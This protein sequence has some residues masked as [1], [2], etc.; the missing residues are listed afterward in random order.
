MK[1][2]HVA[3]LSGDRPMSGS[4]ISR[5]EMRVRVPLAGPMAL[6]TRF[7][8]FSKP[9]GSD[10]E[11]QIPMLAKVRGGK[12]VKSGRHFGI[13]VQIESDGLDVAIGAS[14]LCDAVST[15]IL[16]HT[17]LA[18]EDGNLPS[19]GPQRPLDPKGRQGKRATEGAR[20][21]VRG[22]TGL[23]N[24]FPR[25]LTRSALRTSGRPV[26]IGGKM[27]GYAAHATIGAGVPKQNSFLA[28]EAGRGVE[29]F[30]VSGEVD[31]LVTRVVFDYLATILDGPRTYTAK[32]R[33][34][35]SL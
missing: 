9:A 5:G 3:L 15:A 21:D 10:R 25:A 28:L 1:D 27:L 7:K 32:A 35:D 11:P 30:S 29:Y 12:R 16:G 6:N 20:P 23:P 31:T 14:S 18:I 4:P 22:N 26:K 24:S 33:R 17:S 34:A 13:E 19:G 2:A 8:P